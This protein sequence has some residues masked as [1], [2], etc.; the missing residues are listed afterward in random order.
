MTM[1]IYLPLEDPRNHMHANERLVNNHP[2]VWR[3]LTN[4]EKVKI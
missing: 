2:P 3:V 4:K 1:T